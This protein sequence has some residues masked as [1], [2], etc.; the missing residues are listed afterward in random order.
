MPGL[1]TL[2]SSGGGVP[3]DYVFTFIAVLA[4]GRWQSL[5]LNRHQRIEDRVPTA[6]DPYCRTTW[7]RNQVNFTD[8][9]SL[10]RFFDLELEDIP[11]NGAPGD[12]VEMSTELRSKNRLC[13]FSRTVMMVSPRR[14]FTSYKVEQLMPECCWSVY[15]SVERA[16][17][18]GNVGV[19]CQHE[20][21][22]SLRPEVRQCFVGIA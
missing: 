9:L 3:A 1:E 7:R 12:A 15:I 2:D 17:L 4:P 22:E 10:V 13:R 20:T 18:S 5:A 11:T 21:S 8:L 19:I 6:F 14:E 16:R